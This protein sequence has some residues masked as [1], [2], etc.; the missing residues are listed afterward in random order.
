[1]DEEWAEIFDVEDGLPSDLGAEVFDVDR[2][3]VVEAVV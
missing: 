1:M 2:A 3:S